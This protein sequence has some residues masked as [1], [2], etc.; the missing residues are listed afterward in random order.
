MGQRSFFDLEDRLRSLSALGDP[1]EALSGAI[2]WEELRGLLAKTREKARK[3]NAG[4]PPF[5]VVLMFKVLILQ[6]LY[7]L[8]DGQVEYQIRDR[9]SFSRFLGLGIEDQVPDATTVWRFRERLRE[10]ELTE[11][12][13]NRF[14]DFLARA[15]FQAKAGQIVDASIVPVPIQRNSREENAQIKAGDVPEDWSEA[16]REQ[17]DLDACWTKKNDKS[18]FG[19]KNHISV[20]VEHKLVRTYKV[21]PANVHD[22]QVLAEVLDPDNEDPQVWADSAYRSEAAEANL[23]GAEYESHIHEK[24]QA[25]RPLD[26]AAKERNRTRSKVRARVEHVFGYQENSLGGKLVRTIGLARAEVK[27]GLMNLAYNFKRYLVLIRPGTTAPAV[28]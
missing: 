4:R 5:D 12:L 14:G 7:N 27:I 19:Y 9:L 21:T 20:D 28:A 24:G 3:S 17:K 26:E 10:L 13:F 15:G 6:T 18:F 11:V 23:V 25:N 2:P 1:L 8:A 16:K 22:S